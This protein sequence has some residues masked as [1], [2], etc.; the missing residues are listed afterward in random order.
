MKNR[1]QLTRG[2]KAILLAC[3]VAMLAPI[4]IF[5]ES[6]QSY[7]DNILNGSIAII[8]ATMIVVWQVRKEGEVRREEDNKNHDEEMQKIDRSHNEEVKK[9]IYELMSCVNEF[10]TLFEI[11]YRIPIVEKSDDTNYGRVLES[12]ENIKSFKKEFH[13]KSIKLQSSLIYLY[14]DSSQEEQRS[15]VDIINRLVRI[16]LYLQKLDSILTLDNLRGGLGYSEKDYEKI[17]N[18]MFKLKEDLQKLPKK[19]SLSNEFIKI[20]TQTLDYYECIIECS[21]KYLNDIYKAK[22]K[23]TVSLLKENV[24]TGLRDKLSSLCKKVG[25]HPDDGLRDSLKV[26]A[27]CNDTQGRDYSYTVNGIIEIKRTGKR[28]VSEFINTRKYS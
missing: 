21:N 23:L 14:D 16:E 2:E 20:S 6:W 26:W 19:I 1:N 12:R 15:L 22:D 4:V 11:K 25:K 3:I 17:I 5:K 9:I 7:L 18:N 27:L 10:P 8:P 24:D 28:P 13:Q